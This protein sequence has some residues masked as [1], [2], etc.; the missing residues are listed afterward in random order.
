MQCR[1]IL[2]STLGGCL[3]ASG[4]VP[5]QSAHA[6]LTL[7][8]MILEAQGKTEEAKA[9]FERVLQVDAAAPVAAN[10]LAWL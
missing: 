3:L 10:H 9:R 2:L 7:S 4:L 1:R 6:A 8:G 5:A